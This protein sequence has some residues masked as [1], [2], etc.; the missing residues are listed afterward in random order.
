M[1]ETTYLDDYKKQLLTD[2]NSRNNYDNGRFYIPIANKLVEFANLQHG[3]KILD[4]A[5]GTGIV[6]LNA[7]QKVGVEGKVIGVDI[8]TG[9][10]TNAKR[11]LAEI[12]LQNVEFIEAD[13]EELD[14][15]DNSFDAV[16]CSLAVCY[17][18][19]IPAA[20]R[21]WYRLSKTGGFV[22]FNVWSENAFPPSVL[23]RKVAERYDVNVPN[24]NQSMGT[25]ERSNKL[26]YK[27]GFKDIKIEAEQF[28]WYF[29]V[30]EKIA[31]DIW[32]M[33]AKN[34]FGY[35]V[36]QLSPDKLEECKAEYIKEMQKLPITEKGVWCDVPIFFI[37]AT[38]M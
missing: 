7:A 24:P 20:F 6:A 9:M 16:L 32:W 18:T 13:A 3:Q 37:R 19:D 5:T 33:N 11:K 29:E 22:A 38:I 26:L 4:I 8:S 36:F 10:L 12:G 34:V 23:F 31:E 15:K 30:N 25:I 17:L 35:Q 28:G 27:I 2:F 14:F 1:R 21:K